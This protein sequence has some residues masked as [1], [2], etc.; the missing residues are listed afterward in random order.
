MLYILLFTSLFLLQRKNGG[1]QPNKK[2]QEIITML[3][4][5]KR[6]IEENPELPITKNTKRLRQKLFKA[7]FRKKQNINLELSL[8]TPAEYVEP[9]Q[10]IYPKNCSSYEEI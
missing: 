9:L 6:L 1:A 4:E 8:A 3:Q 5:E 10:V 7:T 2:M